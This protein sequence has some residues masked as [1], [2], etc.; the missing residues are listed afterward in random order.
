MKP[1]PAVPEGEGG[2]PG[3]GA[4]PDVEPVAVVNPRTGVIHR[5]F[6]RRR[7]SAGGQDQ[8][9]AA[10]KDLYDPRIVDFL[11]VVGMAF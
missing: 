9:A 5:M 1:L 10:E 8:Q 4:G 3:D 2:A 7:K 11:D 6:R